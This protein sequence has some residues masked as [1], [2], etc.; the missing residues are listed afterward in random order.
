MMPHM[1]SRLVLKHSAQAA[2]CSHLRD[3]SHLQLLPPVL[4]VEEAVD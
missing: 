1:H 3:R 2:S 4:G